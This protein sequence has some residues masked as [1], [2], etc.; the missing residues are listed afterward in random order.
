MQIKKTILEVVEV[1]AVCMLATAVLCLVLGASWQQVLDQV[2]GNAILIGIVLVVDDIAF[3]WNCYRKLL[4]VWQYWVGVGFEGLAIGAFASARYSSTWLGFWLSVA[5]FV[6]GVAALVL[7]D[8]KVYNVVVMS[9]DENELL[10]FDRVSKKFPKCKDSSELFELLAGSLRFR[11][12]GD[13]LSGDLDLSSPINPDALTLDDLKADEGADE[14][15]VAAHEAYLNLLAAGYF[16]TS[17]D[18]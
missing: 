10:E 9:P 2:C 12:S 17:A 11:L 13:S 14:K 8:W 18:K 15:A 3:K 4:S 1:Y 16:E 5:A 6:I 7:W